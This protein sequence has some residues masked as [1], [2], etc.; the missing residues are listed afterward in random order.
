MKEETTQIVL[1][2]SSVNM[3]FVDS[4]DSIFENYSLIQTVKTL[5]TTFFMF[6]MYSDFEFEILKG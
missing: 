4:P 3:H 2:V 5:K 6:S 1:Y